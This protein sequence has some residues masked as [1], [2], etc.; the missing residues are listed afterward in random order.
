MTDQTEAL[1]AAILN[2]LSAREGKTISPMD[3]ASAV[4][5][6]HPDRW[7]PLMQPLRRIAV[8]LM[9][10]GKIVIL[11]K[12]QPVDPDDFRGTYRLALPSAE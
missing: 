12:G 5:G 10:D 1:E 11:R 6:T 3:V 8:R 2:L 4:G 7:G 9:K